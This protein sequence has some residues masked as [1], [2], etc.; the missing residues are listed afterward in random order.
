MIS[1]RDPK[2][3]GKWN[4]THVPYPTDLCI[5][6]LFE[7]QASRTPGAIAAEHGSRRWSYRELNA[8]ANKLARYLRR[9]G[10][11]RDVPV[12]ICARSCAEL[13]VFFLG[14]LK[15]GGA[16]LPLDPAYPKERLEY[17]GADAK[18]AVVIFGHGI[19]ADLSGAKQLRAE[20]FDATVASESDANLEDVVTPED[21]AY[22]IYTSGSTGQPRGVLLPHRGLVN[23]HYS[24]V[25]LYGLTSADRIPQFSSISF[26]ISIEETYPLWSVGGTVVYPAG[27]FSLQPRAFAHWIEEHGITVLTVA[28]A[29][30]HEMVRE[31][32]DTR[33]PLPSSLRLVAVG[34]EKASAKLVE[35]WYRISD[36]RV[37]WVNTYG[38]S[39]TSVMVTAYEPSPADFEPDPDIPIGRPIPNILTYV[40]DADL[41]PVP[42]GETGELFIGGAGLARGYLNRPELT[43]QKFL[44]DPFSAEPG[45]RMYRTGDLARI[46]PDG[47]IDFRG[48]MDDQVKIRGYRIEP[49]E[50]QAALEQH[51][52]VHQV[53]VIAREDEP[54]QKR[55]AAYVVAKSSRVVTVRA[56]RDFLKD[57]LPEYMIPA[58]FVAMDSMPLTPN[59]KVDK[60]ALPPPSAVAMI[61]SESYA[62]PRDAVEKRLAAIWEQVLG[63]ARVGIADNFFDLGGH[64]LLALRLMR[65]L[66]QT[67]GWNLPP[68]ILFQ[69]P[70]VEKLAAVLRSEE[71]VPRWSSLVPIQP[72]GSKPPFF[73]VHGLGGHVLRFV[74]LAQHLGN[75]RPFYGIQ[76]YGLD[77]GNPPHT[78]VEE[79]AIHYIS[80]IRKL[81]PEGPYLLGG[82]SFGGAVAYEMARR[83]SAENQAV[84]FLALL[85]SY[86]RSA[87]QGPSLGQ[88]FLR[89]STAEKLRYV[90]SKRQM[91]RRRI[92]SRFQALR[93]P[94][95]LKQV[96]AACDLAD[97]AYKWPPYDGSVWWFRA[98][99]KGLRGHD[100]S[101]QSM[102]ANWQVYEIP[103]NHGSIIREP[104]VRELAATMQSCMET[105]VAMGAM[106]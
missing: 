20:E 76:A 9:L 1:E 26:D 42:P 68:A 66:E 86:P 56:L 60:R 96:H 16:C 14:V 95:A 51:P 22:I 37:R 63:V 41:Q 80:E 7:A 75:G 24:I 58:A 10:V 94:T 52:D 92:T 90:I 55:L 83:L 53:V 97:K 85:D 6:Q 100:V 44:P 4:G 54:G 2:S 72:E 21:L 28:T 102:P 48:R 23:H 73:C 70:T 15:S 17:M 38:P 18:P 3:T 50:I 29:Y 43:S 57:R 88:T 93:Y 84:A 49:G 79:M 32:S 91:I 74:A 46:L 5:H 105:S 82:Y 25:D 30:W 62:S 36:G 89:M 8:A 81:Q 71:R 77:G 40:L 34:G 65:R 69:A 35:T 45:A 59:G 99:E 13:P 104:Q 87:R 33:T 98:S 78:T 101:I 39:E 12:G 61:A 31:L 64:S 47:N 106:V 19:S 103:A 11:Q 27:E 67:F